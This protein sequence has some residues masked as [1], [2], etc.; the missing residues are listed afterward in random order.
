MIGCHSTML[1]KLDGCRLGLYQVI[2]KSCRRTQMFKLYSLWQMCNSTRIMLQSSTAYHRTSESHFRNWKTGEIVRQIDLSSKTNYFK[3]CMLWNFQCIT[4]VIFQQDCGLNA[5]LYHLNLLPRSLQLQLVKIWNTDG[6]HR[7]LE[8]VI[9]AIA[10]DYDCSDVIH[11]GCIILCFISILKPT[12]V[13]M[14]NFVSILGVSN[15]VRK[16]SWSQSM[17]GILT[18]G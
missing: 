13:L 18:A 8:D 14:I 10:S 9:Q 4:N 17:K 15:I 3:L 1:M 6:R 7:D 5:R 2:R 11:Q 12:A 16:S